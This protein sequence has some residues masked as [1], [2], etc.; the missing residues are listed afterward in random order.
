MKSLGFDT[1]IINTRPYTERSVDMLM[2]IFY[3]LD[4]RHFIFLHEFDPL[5]DSLP[6]ALDSAKL[7]QERVNAG[8]PRGARAKA[9]MSLK[10]SNETV[11]TPEL[12]RLCVS[13]KVNSLFVSLP[14]FPD[15]SDNDFAASLNRILYRSGIDPIFNSFESICQT[16]PKQFCNKLLAIN[17]CAFVFDINYLFRPDTRELSEQLAY[18]GTQILPCVSHDPSSYV[19]IAKDAELFTSRNGKQLYYKL[20]SQINRCATRNNL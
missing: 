3:P 13:R 8:L 12:H 2:D 1:L 15:P 6:S 18:H 19:G 16:A 4:L 10:F 20:C 11:I 7:F 5:I 14:M 9:L 17:S